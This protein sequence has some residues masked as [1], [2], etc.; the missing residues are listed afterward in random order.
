MLQE[1]LAWA[2]SIGFDLA[3]RGVIPTITF[4]RPSDKPSVNVD[5][6]SDKGVARITFWDSGEYF[7]EYLQTGHNLTQAE[8]EQGMLSKHGR[9]DDP[10]NLVNAFEDILRKM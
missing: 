4:N 3:G 10:Q 5:L 2:E 6:T 9:I 1:F 8:I 7:V